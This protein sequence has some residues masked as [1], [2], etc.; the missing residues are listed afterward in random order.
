MIASIVVYL[1][2]LTEKKQ[3]VMAHCGPTN[4]NPPKEKRK[5]TSRYYNSI[6][7]LKLQYEP[8]IYQI[9]NIPIINYIGA[10]IH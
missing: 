10:K 6:T 7:N 1:I 4:K 8:K 3:R 9:K 5:N 2:K